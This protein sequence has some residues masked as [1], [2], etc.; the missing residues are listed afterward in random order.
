MGDAKP[1]DKDFYCATDTGFISQN[2]YLFAASED[3]STVVVGMVDRKAL[4]PRMS[5]RT[6]QKITLIQP[7]GYPVP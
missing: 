1:E 5:L 3:L 7:V 4:G 6:R 2:V